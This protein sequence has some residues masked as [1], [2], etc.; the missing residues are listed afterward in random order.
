MAL[1]IDLQYIYARASVCVCV[2]VSNCPYVP[3]CVLVQTSISVLVLTVRIVLSMFMT[4]GY[5]T[6]FCDH[7]SLDLVNPCFLWRICLFTEVDKYKY[8]TKN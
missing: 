6:L 8:L 4:Y 1:W 3:A 7:I 5:V 2:C